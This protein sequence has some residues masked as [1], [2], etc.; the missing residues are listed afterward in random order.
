M[1]LHLSDLQQLEELVNALSAGDR[2]VLQA[3]V[4]TPD[5]QIAT[6]RGSANDRLWSK[7]VELTLAREMPL[8][9]EI[10]PQ[11]VNF[12]PR[13]FALTAEGRELLSQSLLSPGEK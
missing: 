8:E 3:S 12:H 10:P 7:L 11:L 13:C 6:V 1:A 9:L 2:S 4:D 5:S